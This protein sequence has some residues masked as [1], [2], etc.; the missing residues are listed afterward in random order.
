MPDYR[1]LG[2]LEVEDGGRPLDLA[3]R[4]LRALLIILLLHANE[5]VAMDRIVDDLWAGSPPRN[6]VTSVHNAVGKLR[7]LVGDH[8]IVT[9]PPGYVLSGK[10]WRSGA[11][12]R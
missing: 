6:A 3:A 1:V 9:R 11:A 4:Q 10:R 12:M 7:R 2:P 8:R 5:V